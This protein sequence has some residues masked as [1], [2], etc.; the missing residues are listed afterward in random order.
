MDIIFLHGF[1]VETLIGVYDWERTQPQLII[2]DLD[3]GLKN[4]QAG[5]T[6]N[7]QD[8]IHY[9]EVAEALRAALTSQH[10]YLLEALAEYIASMVLDDFGAAWI[11]VR[12]T[13]PGILPNI[14]EVG[15]MIERGQAG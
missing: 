11:R 9:G 15:I 3:I 7:I 14:K 8:T 2:L 1:K 13:K 12:V 4:A 6:D 10:F 5:D